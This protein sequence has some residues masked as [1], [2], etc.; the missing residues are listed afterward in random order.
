MEGT[1]ESTELWPPFPISTVI[2][3][4]PSLLGKDPNG[5]LPLKH[6]QPFKKQALEAV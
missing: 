5:K 2:Y 3:F 4:G 1:L 6:V